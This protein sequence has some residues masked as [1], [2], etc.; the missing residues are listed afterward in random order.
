MHQSGFIK[1]RYIRNT[2]W[3]A[4]DSWSSMTQ[5]CFVPIDFQKA[6][7]SVPHAYSQAFFEMMTL[8][9]DVTRLLLALFT[10]QII[11]VI[12]GIPF[13]QYPINPTS[14]VRQGCP[15]SPSMFAMLISPLALKLTAISPHVSILLYAYDLLIIITLPPDE[16]HAIL[17]L[18]MTEMSCF[19]AHT[20]LKMN[21][22]NSAILLKGEWPPQL[23]AALTQLGI[24]IQKTNIWG[25]CW[26]MSPQNSPFPSH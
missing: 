1:G 9:S 16:A 15:L 10:A 11:P 26:D 7:D 19:T 18:I 3:Q 23:Q 5:G 24:P 14:G 4:F 20:G 17:I 13:K 25:S 21:K 12:H 2:V 8:P 6:F 22:G